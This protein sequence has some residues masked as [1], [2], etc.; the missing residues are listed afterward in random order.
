MRSLS[1]L[2]PQHPQSTHPP[3]TD[4]NIEAER[5]LYEI[6]G[7]A[8]DNRDMGR[9]EGQAEGKT[10]LEVLMARVKAQREADRQKQADKI[11]SVRG[12]IRAKPIQTPAT[13]QNFPPSLP[14]ST[15]SKEIKEPM[16]PV[17]KGVL[18][19]AIVFATMLIVFWPTLDTRK[20][21]GYGG[22][23]VSIQYVVVHG[24]GPLCISYVF[25]YALVSGV[26]GLMAWGWAG[27]KRKF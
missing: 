25:G 1:T 21:R 3:P 8:S 27:R 9:A 22:T 6:L 18:T 16:N 20:E 11:N 2:F 10:K 17:K 26:V 5:Q 14:L 24:N 13:V 19:G 12:E 23:N 15:T 7:I 4:A